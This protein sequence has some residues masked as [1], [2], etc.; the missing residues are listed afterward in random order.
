MLCN[1]PRGC[2][3]QRGWI[4]PQRVPTLQKGSEGQRA[5]LGGNGGMCTCRMTHLVLEKVR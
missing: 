2:G 4:L 3:G 5:G 1:K